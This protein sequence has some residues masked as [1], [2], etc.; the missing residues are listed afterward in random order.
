MEP[1]AHKRPGTKKHVFTSQ[2]TP[3]MSSEVQT[4][5]K[6]YRL[7]E[8]CFEP[9]FEWMEQTVSHYSII[10]SVSN[11]LSKIRAVLPEDCDLISQFAQTLTAG[12]TSMVYPFTGFVINFNVSTNLHRDW[13][14]LS[15]C[16]VMVVTDGCEGGDLCFEEAGVRLELQHG[17]VVIFRS[18]ELS[19]FNLNFKG[20]RASLVFHTDKDGEQWAKGRNNWDKSIFMHR[21]IRGGDSL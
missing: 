3:Y 10:F 11:F 16:M 8:D 14:D 21:S 17:D 15:Y 6:E 19:H 1:A 5:M 13:N 4:Y 9:I 20:K 7:I 2:C 12:G 18:N